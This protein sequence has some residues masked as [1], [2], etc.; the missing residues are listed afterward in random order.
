[1]LPLKTSNQQTVFPNILL[2][3]TNRVEIKKIKIW[4]TEQGPKATT[5]PP[6]ICPR[7]VTGLSGFAM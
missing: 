2:T 7:R 1:M 5:E 3:T 6:I 4:Q